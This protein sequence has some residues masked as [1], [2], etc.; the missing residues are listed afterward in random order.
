MFTNNMMDVDVQLAK[1]HA[2]SSHIAQ[3]YG[4]VNIY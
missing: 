4:I 2:I 3:L 1:L